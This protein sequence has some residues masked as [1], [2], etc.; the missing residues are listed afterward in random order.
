MEQSSAML[1]TCNLGGVV[2]LPPSGVLWSFSRMEE[3]IGRSLLYKLRSGGLIVRHDQGVYETSKEIEEYVEEKHGVGIGF[4]GQTELDEFSV[5][6][7]RRSAGGSV[8]S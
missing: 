1:I 3:R 8:S 7:S 6:S 2:E 5:L 4:D